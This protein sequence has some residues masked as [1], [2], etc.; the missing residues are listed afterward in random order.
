[1]MI[2]KSTLNIIL[3][4]IVLCFV[5]MAYQISPFHVNIDNFYLPSVMTDTTWTHIKQKSCTNE[6]EISTLFWV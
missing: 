5:Y 4:S 1:M 3:E 6:K 2:W